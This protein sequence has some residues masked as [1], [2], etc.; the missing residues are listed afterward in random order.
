ML[1]R[2]RCGDELLAQLRD[3]SAKAAPSLEHGQNDLLE[4]RMACEQAA[5]M[6]FEHAPGTLGNDQPERL[7]ETADLVRQL[8]RHLECLPACR[9][10]RADQH[11]VEAFHPHF[12]VEAHLG[13]MRQPVSVVR[14][15]LVRRHIERRLG[16][17]GVDADRRHAFRRQRVIEPD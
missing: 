7:H 8:G 11:A 13:N 15:G 2:A 5:D 12:A 3:L 17:A 16:V 14:V 6:A 1:A 10:Q 4:P 9:D